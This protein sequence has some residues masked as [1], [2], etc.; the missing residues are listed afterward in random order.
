MLYHIGWSSNA[1]TGHISVST[2]AMETCP[3]SCPLINAGCYAKSGPLVMHWRKVSNGERGLSFREF[4]RYIKK[5]PE[6]QLWRHNQAGD[7]P[8]PSANSNRIDS[9]KLKS[10]VAANLGRK[11]FTYT[12]K[13][14]PRD[15]KYIKAANEAGFTINMSC[16]SLDEALHYKSLGIPSVCIV[17]TPNKRIGN[18][19]VVC[20]AQ[21][22]ENVTC[23]D[24]GICQVAN[25]KFVVGFLAH[26]SSQKKV[27]ALAHKDIE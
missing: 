20:P 23:A 5:L 17:D 19:L 22:C 8:G 4:T 7:L 3:S 25:R 10:I 9:R 6:G 14:D 13:K 27:R 16:E 18:D 21:T 15:L 24:C 1:K 2:S 26:G 11:G 12:H